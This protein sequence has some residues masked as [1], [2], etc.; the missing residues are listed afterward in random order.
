MKEIQRRK[1]ERGRKK[2]DGTITKLEEEADGKTGEGGEA[3][4]KRMEL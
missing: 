2:A 4:C 1:T 3:H